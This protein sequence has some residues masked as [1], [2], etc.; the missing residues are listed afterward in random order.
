MFQSLRANNQLYILHKDA[1][2][3]IEFGT[4]VSVSAPRPKYPVPNTFPIPP[5]EMVVDIVVNVNGQNNTLQGL[6]A[7]ADIADSGQNGN[8]VVSSSKEALNNEVMSMRQNSVEIL[9]SIEFHRNI[10]SGCDKMINVLNPELAEKQ[11][12]ETEIKNLREQV[13]QMTANMNALMEMLKSEKTSSN[14]SKK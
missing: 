7:G 6:P 4:I 11:K 5:V 12:Q 2:P 9:N 10:I 14:N 13:S 1:K 8:I 3:Y